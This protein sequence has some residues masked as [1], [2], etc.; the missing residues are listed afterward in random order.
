MI[1]VQLPADKD[2]LAI[3]TFLIIDINT[4]SQMR[5]LRRHHRERLLKKRSKYV[6][7]SPDYD[8]SSYIQGLTQRILIAVNTPTA[9]SC[10]MCGNP[11]KFYKDKTIQEK[12]ANQFLKE[13]LN[14]L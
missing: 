12:R 6:I 2:L 7:Y 10:W 8:S 9:C 14:N 11:R 1:T 5:A 3:V 13:V 4:Q